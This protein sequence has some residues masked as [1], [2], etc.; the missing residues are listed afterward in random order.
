MMIRQK[1]RLH[2]CSKQRGEGEEGN[3]RK[4]KGEKEAQKGR[5]RKESKIEGKIRE[6]KENSQRVSFCDN[7]PFLL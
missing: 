1:E 6:G 3:R 7:S 4:E 2:C 5:N